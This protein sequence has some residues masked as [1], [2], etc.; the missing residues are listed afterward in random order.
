MKKPI[1]I[2]FATAIVLMSG[3]TKAEDDTSR[4]RVV[5]LKA[6]IVR[7][8]SK[9][10]VTDNGQ[11]TWAVGDEIGVWTS[12]GQFTKFSLKSGEAGKA[13]A[14][15]TAE[16]E[17]GVSVSGP[18]VYPYRA[19]HSYNPASQELTYNQPQTIDWVEGVTKSYMA[20]KYTGSGALQFKHLG[21]LFRITVENVPASA[22][23]L[24]LRSSD[25]VLFGNWTVDMSADNPQITGVST[26]GSTSDFN[27]KISPA[28]VPGNIFVANF[29]VPV[30]TYTTTRISAQ[31]SD[32]A[33]IDSK[34]TGSG[35]I[36]IGRGTM[37]NMP[38]VTL[39]SVMLI[40]N[41][42]NTVRANVNNGY[43]NTEAT[44]ISVVANPQKTA[45]N[46]SNYVLKVD[47]SAQD[48]A[49][50]D[51]KGGYF[52][53]KT[54][55][56]DYETNFRNSTKAFRM[57]IRYNNAADAAIYYPQ[58]YSN[59]GTVGGDPDVMRLPDRINGKDFSPKDAETWASLIKPDEWNVLQW[60][61]NCTGTW[62]MEINPFFNLDGTKATAGSRILLIDD[63]EYI[64]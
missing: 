19:A 63:M 53:V 47:A 54:Q 42:E 5:S 14:V 30:G 28:D 15:F 16:L 40:N 17:A 12:D 23:Y 27:L 2:A 55:N 20:A 51:Y 36:N 7:D 61:S 1:L 37:V 64:K 32:W 31:K 3:C 21:G 35:A 34:T 13:T 38:E 39:N 50:D 48:T 58:A 11:V 9:A 29:P 43:G 22:A 24:R 45:E 8:G 57:K 44:A 62:R 33:M 26:G 56:A 49:S 59:G 41:E 52:I 60:T 10:T 25:I 46:A 18:A 4:D 6:S